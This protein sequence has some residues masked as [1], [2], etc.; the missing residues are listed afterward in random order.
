MPM[1]TVLLNLIMSG[2]YGHGLIRGIASYTHSHSTWIF[3]NLVGDDPCW[4]R[5]LQTRVDGIIAHITD[6]RHVRLL[7]R[8]FGAHTPIVDVGHI[9]LVRGI[10][11]VHTDEEQVGRM[12]AEHFMERGFR[13]LACYTY[14]VGLLSRERESAFRRHAAAA[15]L[16]VA[17]YQWPLERPYKRH[18]LVLDPGLQTWLKA[19]PKPVGILAANDSLAFELME[20]CLLAGIHVPE[21]VAVLGVDN[22][23]AVCDLTVPPLSSI[24][25]DTARIGFEAASLLD[26]LMTRRTQAETTIAVPP[27]RVVERQ[28]TDVVALSD[29]KV[30]AAIRFIRLH[31]HEGI[32]VNDI[33]HAIPM[34]RRVLESRFR[35]FLGRTPL[36]EIRR[37]RMEKAKELLERTDMPVEQVAERCGFKDVKRLYVV[38]RSFTGM[39]PARWRRQ[40]RLMGQRPL[41]SH[42]RA[43][44]VPSNR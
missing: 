26:Q 33:L 44:R 23:T 22:N 19:L 5:E 36:E 27:L 21:E 30:A 4:D 13:N 43:V 20:S 31:A 42:P 18:P 2:N 17:T 25:L 11:R 24:E 28:S 29:P 1:K 8:T 38:F 3:R 34:A 14:P 15:G 6:A 7:R 12:A 37:V 32:Q 9:L 41:P 35:R 39:T 16:T 40:F 10:P